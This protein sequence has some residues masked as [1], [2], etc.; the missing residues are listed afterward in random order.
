MPRLFA[1]Q[2]E[3]LVRTHGDDALREGLDKLVEIATD[4][5]TSAFILA[6]SQCGVPALTVADVCK[7]VR[8]AMQNE[9]F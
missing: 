5:T 1:Q 4:S 2:F 3:V 8:D 9:L 6:M 7:T